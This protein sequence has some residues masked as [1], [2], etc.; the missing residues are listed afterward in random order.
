MIGLPLATT[1]SEASASERAN[2]GRA[3]PRLPKPAVLRTMRRERSMG[4][5]LPWKAASVSRGE[6]RTVEPRAEFPAIQGAT[7]IVSAFDGGSKSSNPS[8][9]ATIGESIICLRTNLQARTGSSVYGSF[10]DDLQ[11]PRIQ[12]LNGSRMVSEK[13]L[14]EYRSEERGVG[15]EVR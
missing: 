5:S 11:A 1:V 9:G 7:A 13:P 12:M 14:A 10:S 2:F 6:R 15:K 4:F 8:S 3:N